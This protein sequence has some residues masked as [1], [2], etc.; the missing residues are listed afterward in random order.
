[1]CSYV[2]YLCKYK[3]SLMWFNFN[4]VFNYILNEYN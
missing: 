1:M 3:M 2:Q 4:F